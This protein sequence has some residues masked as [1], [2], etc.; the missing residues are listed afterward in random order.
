MSLRVHMLEIGCL[1][2]GSIFAV[3][4]QLSIGSGNISTSVIIFQQV[5]EQANLLTMGVAY[6]N[7]QT[8]Q[9]FL[10]L[11]IGKQ[12]FQHKFGTETVETRNA[13]IVPI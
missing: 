11:Y 2:A 6:V 4:L 9:R 7:I 5:A 1:K 3:F 8:Y 12:E 13:Y 10:P